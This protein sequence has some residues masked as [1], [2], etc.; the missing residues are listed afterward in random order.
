MWKHLVLSYS[1]AVGKRIQVLQAAHI[2]QSLYFV[3]SR[4][5]PP[6]PSP[7]VLRSTKLPSYSKHYKGG[8]QLTMSA[9]STNRSSLS[10][11]TNF[12]S[13]LIAQALWASL[14]LACRRKIAKSTAVGWHKPSPRKTDL[15][16]SSELH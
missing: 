3:P 5:V 4:P 12:L 6:F 8:T 2:Y 10:V 11:L 14:L 13:I 16:H 15:L 1:R 7:Q 9:H